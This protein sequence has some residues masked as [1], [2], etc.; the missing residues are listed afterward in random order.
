M[1]TVGSVLINFSAGTQGYF[2]G[3]KAV[4]DDAGSVADSF[5]GVGASLT[6]LFAGLGTAISAGAI[7]EGLKSAGEAVAELARDAQKLS[8]STEELS[9]LRFAAQQTGV[10]TGTLSHAMLKLQE[11]TG[12]AAMGGGEAAAK[13]AELGL[14]AK[15]LASEN[16]AQE[17][18]DIATK[19]A[20]IQNPAQRAAAEVALF[21][22]S[23][24]ELGPLL[25]QGASGLAEMGAEADKL[26]VSVSSVDAESTLRAGRAVDKVEDAIS[27]V[28][29]HIAA[30]LAPYIEDAA[31]RMIAWA[32][33]GDHVGKII[34]GAMEFISYGAAGVVTY[35]QIGKAN[36]ELFGGIGTAAL[37][38]LVRAFGGLADAGAWVINK[39]F[40][41]KIDTS[42]IDDAAQDLANKSYALMQSAGHDY[43]QAFSG[44]TAAAVFQYFDNIKAKA[45]QTS[46]EA[47]KAHQAIGGAFSADGAAENVGKITDELAKMHKEVDEFGMS[48]GAKQLH[49]LKLLGATD[50]QQ[51]E[52]AILEQNLEH[53]KQQA[54]VTKELATLQK[55]AR[56]AGMD[57]AAKKVDDLKAMGATAEEI[58]Q[59][60]DLQKHIE[61]VNAAKEQAR[62]LDEEAKKAIESGLS[63]IQKEQ[64]EIA[65]LQQLYAAGKITK[66]Q[67]ASAKAKAERD[68][69]GDAHYTQAAVTRGSQEAFKLM[70]QINNRGRGNGMED[71]A[72]RQLAAQEK[73]PRLLDKL[74]GWPRRR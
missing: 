68:L 16:P 30:G 73:V 31:N 59:A 26:G 24:A 52:A 51:K 28:G 27:G 50:A 8:V 9:K 57:D 66:E 36:F 40:G 7:V 15:A 69:H 44:Q 13:F 61:D 56:Q 20:G 32:E 60:Q 54:D 46:A 74:I 49:D 58:T 63:P 39:L 67:F 19:I 53:L 25:A 22:K 37:G 14:N 45:A 64:A 23:G 33:T 17:F 11:E 10:D 12:K 38:G 6:G 5:G 21:G 18:Q 47:V 1:S 43:Q 29:Q 65:K 62:K 2:A 72:K 35:L 71:I 70:D 48:E 3:S 42:A 34:G 41:T 55:E 4:K